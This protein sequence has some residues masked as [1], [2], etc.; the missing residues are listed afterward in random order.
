MSKF[1]TAY[2]DEYLPT[3]L[4]IYIPIIYFLVF[5]AWVFYR[6][7]IKKDSKQHLN[8]FYIGL[9]FAG[10]WVLIYYLLLR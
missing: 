9:T 4:R 3:M 10:V 7:I 8:N 5:L 1:K 6:V 2:Y